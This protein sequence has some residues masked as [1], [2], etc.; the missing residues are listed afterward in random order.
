MGDQNAKGDKDRAY[1]YLNAIL[2][3]RVSS[4]LVN[5]WN[6]GHSN[7]EGMKAVDPEGLK[8]GGY[9]NLDRF[10]DKTLFQSPIPPDLFSRMNEEF[11]RI[12]A[13]Y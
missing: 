4:V 7:G 11:E 3:T 8:A 9:D 2:D 1:D 6:Y 5:D 12:K 13:G 10:V